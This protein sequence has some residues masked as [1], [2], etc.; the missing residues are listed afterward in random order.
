MIRVARGACPPSLEGPASAGAK[1][2][3]RARAHFE[4]PATSDRKFNFR[5]YKGPD[6]RAALEAMFGLK[7]AYCESVYG[8]TGPMTV[9]HYRPKG[10]YELPDGKLQKPGY[11]WLGSTWTN[12][13]PSCTDCNSERGHDYEEARL[14]TG[15]ANR[16]PLV[17]ESMRSRGAGQER[18]EKPLLL[19]PTVDDPEVHLEF[20]EKGVVAAAETD[21]RECERGG[22]TIEVLGLRRPNLVKVRR[23]HLRKV[24]GAIRRYLRAV[25]RFDR[26][27]GVE[28]R[29]VL[30]EAV[31]DLQDYMEGSSPYAGMA[32]Q[33]IR[34]EL[35]RAGLSPP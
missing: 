6:V 19:D 33:R 9:E 5:A 20:I 10:G 16:F 22:E 13:L 2:A 25:L 3:A 27:G 26:E 17:D 31:A 15:K 4:N 12:L 21:G 7:C 14:V 35:K 18:D 30:V 23:D 29:A 1:E 32:R 8:A 24:E 34:R 28:A 11:W